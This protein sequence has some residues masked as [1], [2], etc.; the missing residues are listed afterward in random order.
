MILPIA[1]MLVLGAAT[2]AAEAPDPHYRRSVETCMVPDLVF[3]NQDGQKVRLRRVL[4]SGEPII[5]D[6]IYTTCTTVCPT[7]STGYATLQMKLGSQSQ[8]VHLISITIDPAL[9]TPKAMK[10]YLKRFRAKPGWD[11]LTGPSEDIERVMHGFN[12]Y[13]PD[14]WSHV[15]LTFLRLPK[16]KKWVRIFGVMSSSEFMDECR[17]A[18]L[19]DGNPPQ[20]LGR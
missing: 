8:K 14:K 10:D 11:F 6:F 12:T 17:K 9:D 5:L 19:L 15:P 20:S 2:L 18:G 16:E 3:L 13:I 1:W 7:L 4:E